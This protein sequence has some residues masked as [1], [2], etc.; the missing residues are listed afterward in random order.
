MQGLLRTLTMLCVLCGFVLPVAGSA[1][2]EG[3][4]LTDAGGKVHRLADYRGKWVIVNFWAT[5][6]P[7]CLEEI[8][9]LVGIAESRRDVQVFGV[10]MEFQDA[11]QVLQ[12]AEGMFVNY[13][14]VLGDQKTAA[15]L[16]EIK[17]LPTTFIYDPT[18][19]LAL[20]HAGKLTRKQIEERI[21]KGRP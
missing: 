18:G 11:K 19:V 13:P 7:P 1:A 20:R 4:T 21:G 12:F 2:A 6:C 17:G 3:F 14:I 10:A 9:D 5:W 15:A 16:G 8:P